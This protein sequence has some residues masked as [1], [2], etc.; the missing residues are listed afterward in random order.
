MP[1]K[2]E[3]SVAIGLAGVLASVAAV[4]ALRNTQYI[5]PTGVRGRFGDGSRGQSWLDSCRRDPIQLYEETRLKPEAFKTL[6]DTLRNRELVGDTRGASAEEKLLTFLYI[7][8][9]G[10]S[11]RNTKYPCGHSLDTISR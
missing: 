11:W 5:E 8:A 6:A 7:C 4:V 9:Q 3:S 1:P 2:L 10:V